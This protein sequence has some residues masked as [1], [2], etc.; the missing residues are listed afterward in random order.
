[1]SN[2]VSATQR[3]ASTPFN[4]AVVAVVVVALVAGGLLL[5]VAGGGGDDHAA[6][7]VPAAAPV[8]AMV[9]PDGVLDLTT[10]A[11][12]TATE[13]RF[14]AGHRGEYAQLRC[15]CGCVDAFAHRSLEECFVR[16]DGRG[17]EA[18]GAGCGVCLGEATQARQ[19]LAAGRTI[20]GIAARLD[21]DFG[22][23]SDPGARGATRQDPG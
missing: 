11:A 15:W 2:P 14:A 21:A 8:T 19:Q 20:A 4:L 9:A 23:T 7:V 5:A 22:P 3:P 13:Y 1:V 12:A 16:A 18:H 10:V 6:R 17:W